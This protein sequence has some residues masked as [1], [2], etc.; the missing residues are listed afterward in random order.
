M[1]TGNTNFGNDAGT[2]TVGA[3]GFN[4][5]V[6]GSLTNGGISGTFTNAPTVVAA[7]GASQGTATQIGNVFVVVVTATTSAQ[8]IKLPTAATGRT[9]LLLTTGTKAPLVYPFLHDKIGT[10]ASNIALQLTANKGG[11]FFAKD[12]VTWLTDL[13]A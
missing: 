10:G 3:D 6:T 9:L 2:G 11:F 7:A 13:G 8:G 4:G 1:A 12:S 5:P